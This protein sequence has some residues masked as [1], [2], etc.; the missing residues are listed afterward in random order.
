MLPQIIPKKRNCIAM[1]CGDS[2][3]FAYVSPPRP[4]EVKKLMANLVFLGLSRG[5]NPSKAM[6]NIGSLNL[7]FSLGRPKNSASSWNIILIKI[8]LQGE[9]K[10]KVNIGY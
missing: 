10:M 8:R 7:S 3:F 2:F 9:K 1:L 4:I 5:S 6:A